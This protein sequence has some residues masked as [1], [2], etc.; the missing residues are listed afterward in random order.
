MRTAG[1][2]VGGGVVRAGDDQLP[3]WALADDV[4]LISHPMILD[5]NYRRRLRVVPGKR[6]LPPS[7][8]GPI[9]DYARLSSP[10]ADHLLGRQLVQRLAFGQVA[11]LQQVRAEGAHEG[12]ASGIEGGWV[13]RA[14]VDPEPQHDYLVLMPGRRQPLPQRREQ[15]ADRL[16]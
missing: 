2:V 12:L 14:R 5:G 13:G 7:A 10:S 4:L 15:L 1:V 3:Q 6:R 16:V 8:G 9:G 11:R